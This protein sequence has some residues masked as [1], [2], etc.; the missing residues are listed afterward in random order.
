MVT[1]LTQPRKEGQGPVDRPRARARGLRHVIM[2]GP[3]PMT[4]ETDAVLG[5]GVSVAVAEA[6]RVW[7][8][9]LR[10]AES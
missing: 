3:H 2:G 9:V 1:A 8:T 5:R 6:E 10:D 4:C 7:N